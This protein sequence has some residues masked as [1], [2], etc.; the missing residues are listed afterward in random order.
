[1]A[2]LP[3]LLNA[4]GRCSEWNKFGTMY[5]LKSSQRSK[6]QQFISL[7]KTVERTA[8]MC[9][10]QNDWR[11]DMAMDD[12]FQN[13]EKYSQPGA[14]RQQARAVDKRKIGQLFDTYRDS[15]SEDKM[16]A[17]GMSRFLDDL[18]VDPT[19]LLVLILAWRFKAETQCEFKRSEFVE[20]MAGL[21]V[22]T[23]DSLKAQLP[24]LEKE[25]S[26]RARF[27]DFYQFTFGFGKTP[28]QKSMDLEMALAYWNIIMKGRFK[29]L[30]LW[31]QFLSENHKRS[32]PRDTWNLLLEFSIS[33]DD[34]MS[35]Y[36]EEG[37][38]P[39]LIDDFVEWARPKIGKSTEV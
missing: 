3:A 37:A 12:Y 36:D 39:V 6:V 29:F 27:R 32:I 16:L 30:D 24:T 2:G 7:T 34:E 14:F 22:D 28:G 9:L 21:G 19:S 17:E 31:C 13:P 35:N 10:S 15:P 38:W 5:K 4:S 18:Q 23:M 1:M 26:E 11:L 25:I 33:I 20:G 8:M